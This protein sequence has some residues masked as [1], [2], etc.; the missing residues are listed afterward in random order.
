M[1]SPHFPTPL[2][3]RFDRY[4][5]ARGKTLIEVAELSGVAARTLERWIA[6]H[7]TPEAQ[8]WEKLAKGFEFPSFDEFWVDF[9]GFVH[10][11]PSLSSYGRKAVDDVVQH[12]NYGASAEAPRPPAYA[13]IRSSLDA[14]TAALGID[15]E[16]ILPLELR[17]RLL[18]LRARNL[19]LAAVVEQDAA[20]YFSLLLRARKK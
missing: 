10:R 9:C 19:A 18:R 1:A 12:S 15:L 3:Y 8:M 7:T 17:E 16:T 13:A 4:C 20:E 14:Q 11:N 2:S 5:A 6:G